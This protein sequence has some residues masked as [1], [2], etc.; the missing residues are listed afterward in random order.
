MVFACDNSEV[1]LGVVNSKCKTLRED[2]ITVF[3]LQSRDMF[4]LLTAK[5][6]LQS[7]GNGTARVQTLRRSHVIYE[8]KQTI[9]TS[10]IP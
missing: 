4:T 10:G 7:I 9:W 2:E 1:I 8:N 5:P 3:F 6:N